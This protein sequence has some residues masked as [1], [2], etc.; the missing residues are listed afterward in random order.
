MKAPRFNLRYHEQQLDKRYFADRR[1]RIAI[2]NGKKKYHKQLA[3][4][5][6]L[7]TFTVPVDYNVFLT[8]SPREV[9]HWLSTFVIGKESVIGLDTESDVVCLDGRGRGE[10]KIS[11]IQIATKDRCL[12]YKT[13]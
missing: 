13:A 11:I 7:Q 5:K 1:V 8:H 9:D 3:E 6:N 4:N 12:I 2:F 10:C